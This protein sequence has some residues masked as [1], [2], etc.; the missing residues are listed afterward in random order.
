MA[1]VV[2]KGNGRL[3]IANR[4]RPR[5]P[6]GKKAAASGRP[7]SALLAKTRQKQQKEIPL[8]EHPG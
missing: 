1:L 7:R 5:P 4:I 3:T 8:R 6:G 2:D